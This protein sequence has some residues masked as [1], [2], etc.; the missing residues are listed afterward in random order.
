MTAQQSYPEMTQVWQRLLELLHHH[1]N[2]LDYRKC[3]E[4][5][6]DIVQQLEAE[7][8]LPQAHYAFDNGLLCRELTQVIEQHQK[9][10]LSELERSRLIQWQGRRVDAIAAELR[11]Q[12]PESFRSLQVGCRSAE[13]KQFWAFTKTV[14]LKK[15]GRKRLVIVHELEDLSD[16]PR[17]L[18][19][20][21]LP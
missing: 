20:D 11:T 18:L 2:G 5:A 14:R 17:Y 7:G 3:T 9:H 21:A 16:E 15:Y 6:V 8:Q 13:V 1:K 12:H 10:W 19:T 4:I